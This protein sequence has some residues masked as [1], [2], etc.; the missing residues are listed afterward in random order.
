M[1]GFM[2]FWM[3]GTIHCEEDRASAPAPRP[4]PRPSPAPSPAP[5]LLDQPHLQL[6]EEQLDKEAEISGLS[7]PRVPQ[8]LPKPPQG[9]ASPSPGA[10]AAGSAFGCAG[11]GES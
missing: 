3:V 2:E 4:Q 7:A 5:Y 1:K 8:P 11:S 6:D 9:P 10:A